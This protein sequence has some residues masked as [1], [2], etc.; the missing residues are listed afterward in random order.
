MESPRDALLE[1]CQGTYDAAA[2]LG[3]WDRVA[4]EKQPIK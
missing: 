3:H 2:D 4:L 1:F